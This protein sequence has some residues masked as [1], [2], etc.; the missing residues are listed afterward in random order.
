MNHNRNA[1]N[2]SKSYLIRKARNEIEKQ[3]N[4]RKP[5]TSVNLLHSELPLNS[6]SSLNP[7]NL[8]ARTF[9]STLTILSSPFNLFSSYP[10]EFYGQ[11]NNFQ[12]VSY[13][14]RRKNASILKNESKLEIELEPKLETEKDAKNN[15]TLNSTINKEIK[16]EK[17]NTRKKN[18]HPSISIPSFQVQSQSEPQYES[19]PQSQSQIVLPN[20]ENKNLAKEE[21]IEEKDNMITSS[22]NTRIDTDDSTNIKNNKKAS[23]WEASEEILHR[24]EQ[25]GIIQPDSIKIKKDKSSPFLYMK[26]ED[27]MN[28]I[29]VNISPKNQVISNIYNTMKHTMLNETNPNSSI[30]TNSPNLSNVINTSTISNASPNNITNISTTNAKSSTGSNYTKYINENVDRKVDTEIKNPHTSKSIKLSNTQLSNLEIEDSILVDNQKL[31]PNLEL[32]NESQLNIKHNETYKKNYTPKSSS[33]D[34]MDEFSL[35]STLA[36]LAKGDEKPRRKISEY[37]EPPEGIVTGYALKSDVSTDLP[38]LDINVL[39]QEIDDS[40]PFLKRPPSEIAYLFKIRHPEAVNIYKEHFQR[41][42]WSLAEDQELQWNRFQYYMYPPSQFNLILW[43]N[44]IRS[45]DFNLSYAPLKSIF[46]LLKRKTISQ[47]WKIVIMSSRYSILS[48]W[49]TLSTTDYYSALGILVDTNNEL[50]ALNQSVYS[51]LNILQTLGNAFDS[52]HYNV[53]KFDTSIPLTYIGHQELYN[54]LMSHGRH[55]TVILNILNSIQTVT[56]PNSLLNKYFDNQQ[57]SFSTFD[58]LLKNKR[59]TIEIFTK[60]IGE[61]VNQGKLDIAW[62]YYS[63]MKVIHK[64][65]FDTYRC[66][67][68]FFELEVSFGG[69]SYDDIILPEIKGP[70]ILLIRAETILKFLLPRLQQNDIEATETFL[71]IAPYIETQQFF[72]VKHFLELFIQCYLQIDREKTAQL[73]FDIQSLHPHKRIPL[74][75]SQEIIENCIDRIDIVESIFKDMIKVPSFFQDQYYELRSKSIQCIIVSMILNGRNYEAFDMIRKYFKSPQLGSGDIPL[76]YAT[77]RL[78]LYAFH[79]GPRNSQLF[80]ELLD[81]ETI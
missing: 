14:T 34:V 20:L 63:D 54:L 49:I 48:K 21:K 67:E 7:S 69:K 9:L 43:V 51:E 81:K 72:T 37:I 61:A 75:V 64:D 68:M 36:Q 52:P 29:N 59:S 45:S 35:S 15:S 4:K 70:N 24:L 16:N 55:S 39:D 62:K 6:L 18:F 2:F 1:L 71:K 66:N 22:E 41:D 23:V 40:A 33:N 56:F 10:I 38:Q 58:S 25:L 31:N 47:L 74:E 76:T 19:E 27:P 8:S 5:S 12:N 73:Y 60:M 79:S 57:I 53:S 42:P 30:V 11:L 26:N 77:K 65:L 80:L 78:F 44:A 50:V 46:P 28:Y 3:N 13:S 32:I 17:K